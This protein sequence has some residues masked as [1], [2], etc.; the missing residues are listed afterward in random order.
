VKENLVL[1]KGKLYMLKH[2]KLKI[3]IIW[4][5]HDVPVAE[6]EERW[7]TTELVIRNYW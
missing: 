3:E 1:K 2:K 7:K 6:Y 4:L 5:H